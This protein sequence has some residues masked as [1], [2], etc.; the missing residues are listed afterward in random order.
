[1]SVKTIRIEVTRDS[2]KS[3]NGGPIYAAFQITD[4]LRERGVPV[5]GSI[6]LEGVA[7]G[8]LDISAQDEN[9]VYTWTGTPV[10]KQTKDPLNDEWDD[11]EL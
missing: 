7:H 1:M 8:K 2:F 3:A 9:I 5:I 6:V 4:R 11:G 10:V